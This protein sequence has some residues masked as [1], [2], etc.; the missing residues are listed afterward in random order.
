MDYDL[1]F[2]FSFEVRCNKC[3]TLWSYANTIWS[4][5]GLCIVIRSFMYSYGDFWTRGRVYGGIEEIDDY[6]ERV[7]DGMD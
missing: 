6:V 5:I 2:C 3:L 4:T 7:D 1:R